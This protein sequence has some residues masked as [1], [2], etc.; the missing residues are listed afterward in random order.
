MPRSHRTTAA[1]AALTTLLAGCADP[2]ASPSIDADAPPAL[3]RAARTSCALRLIDVWEH[4]NVVQGP[5]RATLR[6]GW[7]AVGDCPGAPL[8]GRVARIAQVTVFGQA[9]NDALHGSTRIDVTFDRDVSAIFEGRAEARCMWPL[10]G[11]TMVVRAVGPRGSK[12]ASVTDLVIDPFAGV[13]E[14]APEV[15]HIVDYIDPD[16]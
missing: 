11:G 13:V 7:R 15:V 16:L 8:H 1:L 12:L 9:G 3:A 2:P 10:C 14:Y 4:A 6:A 5:S